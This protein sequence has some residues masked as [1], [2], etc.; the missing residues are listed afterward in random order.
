MK[1]LKMQN[2]SYAYQDGNQNRSILQ[3]LSYTFTTGKMYAIVGQS[4]SGKTTLI[5]LMS[6][7]DKIQ[8]GQITIE[9]KQ[10]AQIGYEK[11]RSKYVSMVFQSYHL[12]KYMTAV[13]NVLVAMGISKIEKNKVKARATAV[14]L[15]ADLGIDES[16]INRRITE[17]SGGEQQR[18]AIARAL[19]TQT[20]FIF[21]DEPTGNLDEQTQRE[22]ISILQN[23]AHKQQ[24]CVIVVT[25]APE[26]ALIADVTLKLEHQKLQEK[27]EK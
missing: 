27:N 12:I 19:S 20:D 7:L 9:E 3:N 18:V 6:G 2:I 16:K 5:S 23:L 24:K 8:S 26:I 15:L 1:Q 14:Q 21:A 17:L 22:I 10:I 13:E 25:H 11:Y 4:G